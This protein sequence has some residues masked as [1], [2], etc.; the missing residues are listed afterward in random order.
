LHERLQGFLRHSQI[1]GEHGFQSTHT[2]L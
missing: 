1:L 2:V